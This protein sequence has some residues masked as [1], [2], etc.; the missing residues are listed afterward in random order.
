MARSRIYATN[1][2]YTV[3]DTRYDTIVL[4]T[5]SKSIAERWAREVD[6]CEHP[7]PYDILA[8]GRLAYAWEA[9]HGKSTLD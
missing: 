3:M 8:H 6:D 7:F 1:G 9:K 5:E 2:K 4:Q